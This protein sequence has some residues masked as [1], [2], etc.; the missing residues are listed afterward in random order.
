MG[1][2]MHE[3]NSQKINVREGGAKYIIYIYI[4]INII[5]YTEH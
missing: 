3:I 5:F 4:I 2:F 1:D